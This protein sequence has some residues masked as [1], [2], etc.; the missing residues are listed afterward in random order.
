[1]FMPDKQTEKIIGGAID[2][3]LADE[4]DRHVFGKGFTKKTLFKAFARWWIGLSEDEQKRFYTY[5][6]EETT[7]TFSQWVERLIDERIQT[8]MASTE[9]KLDDS[10]KSNILA[11]VENLTYYVRYKLPSP[12]EQRAIAALRSALGPD[13]TKKYNKKSAS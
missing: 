8:R 11:S 1:M 6:T 12:E 2:I 3:P 9:T 7:E 13:P 10:P 5:A 4:F